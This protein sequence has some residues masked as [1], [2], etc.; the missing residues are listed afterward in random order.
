MYVC[1]CVYVYPSMGERWSDQIYYTYIVVRAPPPPPLF[2][3]GPTTT[4][5]DEGEE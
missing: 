4:E 1:M 2:L 3:A 5:V